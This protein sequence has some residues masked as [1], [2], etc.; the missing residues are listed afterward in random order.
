MTKFKASMD[1]RAIRSLVRELLMSRSGNSSF[2]RFEL[3]HALYGLNE[4]WVDEILKPEPFRRSGDPGNLFFFKLMALLH[5]YFHIG[6]GQKKYRALEL[7]ANELGQST[8]TLRSWEKQLTSS[9]D[10][11]MTEL[12]C[13]RLAGELESDLDKHSIPELIKMH[14]ARFHRHTAE[15]EYASRTL[16]LVRLNPL[17][18]IRDGLRSARTGKNSGS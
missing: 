11:L 10:D 2:W 4:G 17:N 3:Q 5:V 16:K 14:G 1:Q 12:E 13:S 8:E 7:V 6:K 15:V 9:D 18:E